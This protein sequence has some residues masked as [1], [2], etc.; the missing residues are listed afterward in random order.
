MIR[1]ERE[2]GLPRIIIHNISDGSEHTVAFNE[3]AHSLGL[4]TG[5]EFDTSLI[6]FSYSSMTTP[7]QVF[8]YDIS[9]KQR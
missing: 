9:S 8:D 7:R 3:D 1:L 4:R 6:R 5:Y 2:N